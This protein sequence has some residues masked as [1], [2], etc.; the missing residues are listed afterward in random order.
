MLLIQEAKKSCRGKW[1]MP[2]GRVE[3]GETIE[4]AVVREV[5]E[6]TG[7]SCDVVELLSL[8][9]QGSGWYRYAFYCNITGEN[10]VSLFIFLLKIWIFAKNVP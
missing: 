4:E 1:Y 7:Y 8:Q 5:K 9:V 2:A 10:S 6:E 3:A